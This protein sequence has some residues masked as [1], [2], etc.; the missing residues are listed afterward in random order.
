MVREGLAAVEQP[1]HITQ[2]LI[3]FPKQRLVASTSSHYTVARLWHAAPPRCVGRVPSAR[4]GARSPAARPA[5]HL[6]C[7]G[8][9]GFCPRLLLRWD[10]AAQRSALTAVR[11]SVL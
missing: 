9:D 3:G 6:R 4:H 11:F 1:A 5:R 8:S 2:L 10:A 7:Q